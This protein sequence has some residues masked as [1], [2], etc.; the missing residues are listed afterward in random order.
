[1][2]AC[3]LT[4]CGKGWVTREN[5]SIKTTGE[6]QAETDSGVFTVWEET[7]LRERAWGL[8]LTCNEEEPE[9]F[10]KW[11]RE[12]L[13]FA[14]IME[15]LF[16][17]SRD[18]SK[19]INGLRPKSKH[20]RFV[21][22]LSI[23]QSVFLWLGYISIYLKLDHERAQL[24]AGYSTWVEKVSVEWMDKFKKYS[25]GRMLVEFSHTWE[26]RETER[27]QRQSNKLGSKAIYWSS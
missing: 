6:T 10:I 26:L 15:P 1:M 8:S 24:C 9:K 18:Q 14:V 23:L 7:G 5:S 2:K 17:F 11:W 12:F 20:K 25:I 4:Y 16:C 13:S 22:S 21:N 27:K 3:W 19:N